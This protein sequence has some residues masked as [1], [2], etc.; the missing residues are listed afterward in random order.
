ME[1][2]GL[3]RVRPHEVPKSLLEQKDW[4][5]EEFY[6]LSGNRAWEAF[7]Y[8]EE[9]HPVGCFMLSHTPLHGEVV[10][11]TLIIDRAHRSYA[12]L[13]KVFGAAK[14]VAK[15]YAKMVGAD[16]VSWTTDHPEVYEKRLAP[17]SG[18]ERVGVRL[19][20]KA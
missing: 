10:I 20:C 18:I 16:H 1:S 7:L 6:G 5:L 15:A 3:K 2:V 9:G 19:R 4:D 12:T 13:R 8:E 11:D 14:L 17:N